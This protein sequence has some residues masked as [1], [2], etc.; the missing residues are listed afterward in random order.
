MRKVGISKICHYLLLFV[1]IQQEEWH[2]IIKNIYYVQKDID[3]IF[4]MCYD[5]KHTDR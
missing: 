5:I 1:D 2:K 4:Y 3:D